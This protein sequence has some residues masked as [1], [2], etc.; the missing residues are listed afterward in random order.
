MD[1]NFRIFNLIIFLLKSAN[2]FKNHESE[3]EI[4]NSDFDAIKAFK[5]LQL[6]EKEGH[7]K[8][9]IS[10]KYNEKMNYYT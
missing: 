7:Y 1:S 6:P 9:Q 10:Q 8:K 5:Y 2:D 4:V 3:A